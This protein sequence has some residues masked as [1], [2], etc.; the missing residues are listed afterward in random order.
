MLVT[1]RLQSSLAACSNLLPQLVTTYLSYCLWWHPAATLWALEKTFDFTVCQARY[2]IPFISSILGES[3][4]W[5]RCT[6]MQ[7]FSTGSVTH[8]VWTLPVCGY[9]SRR[10]HHSRCAVCD[11]NSPPLATGKGPEILFAGQKLNDNEWHTVKVVRRGK[12]LQLSVDN[13]TVEGQLWLGHRGIHLGWEAVNETIVTMYSQILMY[14]T[15]IKCT[16]LEKVNC[17][18]ICH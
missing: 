16:H 14:N 2:L 4:V 15:C 13:V 11:L 6:N 18:T 12:S 3:I 7:V 9:V 10:T 1:E 8:Y 5:M 17:F